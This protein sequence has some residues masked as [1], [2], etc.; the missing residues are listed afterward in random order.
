MRVCLYACVCMYVY[1]VVC[2]C[3]FACMYVCVGIYT[4]AS[5]VGVC[6]YEIRHTRYVR[7]GVCV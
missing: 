1:V 5:L 4:L 7:V 3:V 2:L 6:V